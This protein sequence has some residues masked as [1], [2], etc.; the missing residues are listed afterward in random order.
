MRQLRCG[1]TTMVRIL[2][3]EG[4]TCQ[5]FVTE[6]MRDKYFV[7]KEH[8]PRLVRKYGSDEALA[9]R[10]ALFRPRRPR[11]PLPWRCQKCGKAGKQWRYGKD[12]AGYQ[13]AKCGHCKKTYSF[14]PGGNPNLLKRLRSTCKWCG[15]TTQQRRDGFARGKQVV[16]CGHCGRYYIL[17]REDPIVEPEPY[18]LRS[19]YDSHS[20]DDA[21]RDP[22]ITKEIAD[23]RR[24]NWI[25]D[26]DW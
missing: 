5:R 25:V 19:P 10:K 15:A 21:P 4:I 8:V 13:R 22:G 20:T 2:D 12:A 26:L 9:A 1:F 6:R 17:L 24:R 7:N 18:P 14:Y 3:K 23:L 16:E 11:S